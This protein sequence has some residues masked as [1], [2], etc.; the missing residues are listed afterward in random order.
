MRKMKYRRIEKLLYFREWAIHLSIKTQKKV[1][2][3]MMLDTYRELRKLGIVATDV[4][5]EPYSRLLSTIEKL[6][7]QLEDIVKKGETK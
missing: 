6:L 3:K 5:K 2:L 7:I 1:Y 4:S